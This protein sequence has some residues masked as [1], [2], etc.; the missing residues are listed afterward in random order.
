MFELHKE[1]DILGWHFLHAF[2]LNRHKAP[3]LCDT[4][5]PS[6]PQKLGEKHRHEHS[7]TGGEG[8]EWTPLQLLGN[9]IF[10]KQAANS[11]AI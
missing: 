5:R 7:S 1:A 10:D 4:V 3:W 2:T 8:V 6:N 9:I 11:K